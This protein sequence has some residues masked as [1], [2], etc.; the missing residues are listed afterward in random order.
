MDLE[1]LRIFIAVMRRGSFSAV[2]R[3]SGVPTSS[4]SRAIAALEEQL[5][6]RLFQRTTRRVSPTEVGAAYFARI[7]PV[8]AEI[9]QAGLA[10][11]DLSG[12][13]RGTL[14]ITASVS[15]GLTC[16]VPLL[17]AFAEQQP[18]LSLDLRL[19]D[20]VVDLT[21]EGIDLAIRHGP[22]ADSTLVARRLLAVEY[23]V[24]ASPGYLAAVG[25]PE[26]LEDLARHRCLAFASVG[27]RSV[28]SFR[29]RGTAD[30]DVE[31]RPSSTINNGIALKRCAIDGAGLVVLSDWL[32]DDALRDG[33][34]V[35]ILR[36]Y[37]VTPSRFDPAIWLLYPSRAYVPGKVTAF[38]DFLEAR[39]AARTPV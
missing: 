20:A 29:R 14:R 1:A 27:S 8:V 3:E 18:H 7:E 38:A 11:A 25:Q 19:T 24:F 5:G 36:D 32:V 30:R 16:V 21:E 35:R 33:S 6:V 39:L 26:T 9:E 37:E 31:F 10:V 15:F 17:A 4:I 12:A 22:L 2:A 23:A 34:L 28:W 13:P